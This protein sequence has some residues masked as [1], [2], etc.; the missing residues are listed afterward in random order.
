MTGTVTSRTVNSRDV[1]ALSVRVGSLCAVR[2]ALTVY[3]G[4]VAAT[5]GADPMVGARLAHLAVVAVLAA[6]TLVSDRRLGVAAFMAGLLVDGLFLQLQAEA[7]GPAVPVE[8]AVILHLVAVCLLASARSGLSMTVWQSVVMNFALRAEAV[9]LLPTPGWT[10]GVDRDRT[11]AV[12]FGVY[13][14]AALVAAGAVAVSE[15]EL[16][17]RRY[18]A[19]QLRR[20]AGDLIVDDH[21]DE[22]ADRLCRF[23]T[24]ELDATRAV[25]FTV[26]PDT[27]SALLAGAADADQVLASRLDPV[28]DAALAAALP[29][30]RRLV[31]LRLAPDRWL[32]VEDGRHRG[33]R[34]AARFVSTLRQAAAAGAIAWSRAELL[35]A[36]RRAAVTDGLTGLAN[37]RQ[38]DQ[39]C[40]ELAAAR[41]A[42]GTPFALVLADVDRFKSIND[43]L[44]H[45]AGDE[46]LQVVASVL[47]AA[48]RPT[49]L[50]ARY[51]GE[52]FALLLPGA[53]LQEAAAVA[54][55]ARRALHRAE[56]PLPVTASFGVAV[57][58]ADAEAVIRVADERLLAAKEAGRDRVVTTDPAGA[59]AVLSAAS[60]A[61]TAAPTG[62]RRRR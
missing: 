8:H 12:Q 32:V 47:A 3:L 43:T 5:A 17:R 2:L 34:V 52:E 40:R 42:D 11:V 15:R 59:G 28:A 21:P 50:A 14:L 23:A 13:W 19:D 1:A 25:V 41:D 58:G 51:G 49:D 30:A 35:E 16:R 31:G 18:D 48:V 36:S 62:E 61:G 60:P 33:L 24:D 29:E 6:L 55:R 39:R 27:P 4:V 20:L 37:R 56:A 46:V 54:E 53:S 9:G 22:V 7:Y 26:G 38:F 10:Q 57:G 44:G 45:Q